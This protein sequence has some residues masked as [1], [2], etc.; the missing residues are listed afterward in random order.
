M[1]KNKKQLIFKA[2]VFIMVIFLMNTEAFPVVLLNG[3]AGGYEDP[4][5]G[6]SNFGSTKEN[7]TIESYIEEGGGYFLNAFSNIIIISNR[8]EMS[9]INGIDYEELKNIVDRAI[10]NVI[11]AKVV[12]SLLI[13]KA[14]Y[15]PYDNEF[16]S[17]LR[18]FNYQDLMT[19]YSLNS[20]IFK[21][22]EGYLKNR[23]ITGT[24]IRIYNSFIKIE[25]L[26]LSIKYEVSLNRMPTIAKI[27]E[28]NEDASKTLIFG[29]YIAR[30]FYALQKNK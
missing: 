3:G 11:N 21:E 28:V 27:W 2:V 24:F 9:N 1:I 13:N 26:L 14:R 22:V 17:K 20:E 10:E 29:Q 23:D 19:E 30:F 12:Y 15:T 6:E 16:I 4:G 7:Y 8:I 5:G 18:S 25:G